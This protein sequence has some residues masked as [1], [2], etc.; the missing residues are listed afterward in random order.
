VNP[1]GLSDAELTQP[2]D[3][4]TAIANPASGIAIDSAPDGIVE[5]ATDDLAVA[6]EALSV[7]IDDPGAYDVVV[8]FAHRAPAGAASALLQTDFE[9]AVEAFLIAGGGF[10]AFHHGNYRTTGKDGIQALIGGEATGA[11][12]WN[13]LDG[14]NV[15][16]LAVGH[17]V[18]SNAVTYPNSILYQDGASGISPA[19]Y[20]AFNNTPDERYPNLATFPGA[21]GI[22]LL[23]AS[24]YDQLGSTHLLGFT[25]REPGWLGIVVAVQP[26]EYQPTALDDLSGN[27]FQILAN[28]IF[29]AAG[30]APDAAVPALDSLG[31]VALVLPI[32]VLGAMAMRP[33]TDNDR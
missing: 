23:F 21:Q 26:G 6:T 25:H 15:I 16:N 7:P 28:A 31:V 20:P 4:L 19:N 5:I 12:P 27:G 8:Y 17:F 33:T 10:V 3:L 32:I 18:T 9:V 13:T 1:H 24:D 22:E 30:E 29:F 2:G 11:V 14:Q